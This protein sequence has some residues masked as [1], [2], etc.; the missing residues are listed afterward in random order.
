MKPFFV[1]IAV[2]ALSAPF[3]KLTRKNWN[4]NVAGVLAL[5]AMLIFS[6]LGHFMFPD[7]MAM[8]IPDFLPAKKTL[9]FATGFLEIIFAVLI[10]FKKYRKITGLAIII[11]LILVLPSNILASVNN[12]NYE[13]GDYK[14]EGLPYHY[15]RIP[16]QIFYIVWMYLFTVKNNS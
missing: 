1:L 16:L 13:T 3:F 8:M 11:F 7:G 2:F 15:F 4:L 12:V 14:G 10:L 6:S 5:S 9:V